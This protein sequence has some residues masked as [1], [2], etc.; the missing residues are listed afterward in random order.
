MDATRKASRNTP[1]PKKYAPKVWEEIVGQSEAVET[2]KGMVRLRVGR[3]IM[4]IGESGTGKSTLAEVFARAWTCDAPVGVNPCNQCPSC[5]A[6]L[7]RQ[8]YC[9][10]WADGKVTRIG[11]ADNDPDKA[12]EQAI[13]AL[14]LSAGV[15]ILNEADR[16]LKESNRLL[17]VLEHDP[18]ELR[19]VI[20]TA[21]KDSDFM[22]HGGQL[23]GR[24][25]EL[26]T[27]PVGPDEMVTHLQA[28]HRKETGT[29]LPVEVATKL[30]E[31]LGDRSGRVR[32]ALAALEG[33]ILRSAVRGAP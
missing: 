9:G 4:L 22:R 19:P 30:I 27:E 15:V 29:D 31:R 11:M 23:L 33:H 20:L 12:V 2:L 10:P 26:R 21:V 3:P 25:L 18:V 7:D 28:I 32:D 17:T 5:V 24:C 14:Y 1:L 8:D 16:M 6:N 13:E